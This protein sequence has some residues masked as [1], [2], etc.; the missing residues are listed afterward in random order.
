MRDTAQ[1]VTATQRSS[2]SSSTVAFTST[3]ALITPA[4]C[5]ARPAARIDSFC[6]AP[7]LRMGQLGALLELLVDHR[8]GQL[9]RRD[10]HAL[11]VGVVRERMLA[12]RLVDREHA[13]HEVG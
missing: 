9:G 10:E 12:R 8:L 4:C 13:A 1:F 5:S 6:G 11:H 2:I 3:S 7:M